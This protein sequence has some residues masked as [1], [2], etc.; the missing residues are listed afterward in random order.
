MHQYEKRRYL[1][2]EPFG[3][4]RK[5]LRTK[6]LFKTGF[7]CILQKF[8]QLISMKLGGCGT[9]MKG[10]VSIFKSIDEWKFDLRQILI[11]DFF[12]C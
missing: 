9:M 8:L 2:F 11:I 12:C 6:S 1:N 3:A 7:H 5:G 10:A 4:F